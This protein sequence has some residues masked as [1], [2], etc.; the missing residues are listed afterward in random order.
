MKYLLAIIL[1]VFALFLTGCS[2]L[3]PCSEWKEEVYYDT[4]G[5]ALYVATRNAFYLTQNGY[6]TRQVCV[7]RT[8]S[9]DV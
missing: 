3:P 7:K 6:K 1:P 9:S 5:T 2:Q 4:Q 8:K